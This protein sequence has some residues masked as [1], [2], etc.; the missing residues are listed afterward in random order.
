MNFQSLCICIKQPIEN[1]NTIKEFRTNLKCFSI[2]NYEKFFEM[3][4]EDN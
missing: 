4:K 2:I 1:K 3:I